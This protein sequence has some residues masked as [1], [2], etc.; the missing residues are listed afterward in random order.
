MVGKGAVVGKLVS[1]VASKAL[2]EVTSGSEEGP[3][4]ATRQALET[5]MFKNVKRAA[6][7]G[8]RHCSGEGERD[9]GELTPRYILHL[10]YK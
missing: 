2:A 1:S 4:S 7:H 10:K 9:G 8:S 6:V 5:G 3:S